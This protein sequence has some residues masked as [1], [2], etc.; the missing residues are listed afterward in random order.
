MYGFSLENGS[1]GDTG[2]T[3]FHDSHQ[4]EKMSNALFRQSVWCLV[5]PLHAVFLSVSL[6]ACPPQPRA[7]VPLFRDGAAQQCSGPGPHPP[8]TGLVA[9]IQASI[10]P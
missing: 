9:F 5:P 6:T 1:C 2:P 10:L 7:K 4:L 3:F 8:I